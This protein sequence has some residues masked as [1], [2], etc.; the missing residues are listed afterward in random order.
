[1]NNYIR[2]F[3]MQYSHIMCNIDINMMFFCGSKELGQFYLWN[4]VLRYNV[5]L[6]LFQKIMIFPIVFMSEI[7]Q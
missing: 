2:D 5:Y 1:M 6:Q 4:W 3:Q 7:G